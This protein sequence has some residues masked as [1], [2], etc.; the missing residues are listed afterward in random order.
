M[1]ILHKI[2]LFS[3]RDFINAVDK[4]RKQVDLS[5]ETNEFF[6][7]FLTDYKNVCSTFIGDIDGLLLNYDPNYKVKYAPSIMESERFH[8]LGQMIKILCHLTQTNKK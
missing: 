3:H 8:L 2:E 6:I 4:F 7:K 1:E 5:K